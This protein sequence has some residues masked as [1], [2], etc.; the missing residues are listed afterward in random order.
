MHPTCLNELLAIFLDNPMTGTNSI[1]EFLTQLFLELKQNR[2]QYSVLRN[3][4][5]LPNSTGGSDIDMWVRNMDIIK[6]MSVFKQVS[7]ASRLSLVSYFG[8]KTAVKI[9]LQNENYGVQFDLFLGAIYYKETI[10]VPSES[11]IR[12]SISY[13][14]ITVLNDSFSDLLAYLKELVNNTKVKEKYTEP[15]LANKVVYS[16]DYLMQ[17][18][19]SFDKKFILALSHSIYTS[20]INEDS[21]HLAKLCRSSLSS[22]NQVR[23]ISIWASKIERL[24]RPKPGYVIAVEGTDGSGKSFIINSITPTLNEAFH[25]G[26]VYKHLRPHCIPDIAELFGKRKKETTTEATHVVSDPHAERS[27]GFAGSLVRWLYYMIDYTWGYMRKVWLPIHS[28]SK[29]F[30]FDRY[31]YEYYLDQRRSHVNLPMWIIRM[32]EFFIPKPDLIICLGGDPEKIYARKP[33]TSLEEVRRQTILLKEFCSK[34][35]NA[36][37][38]DTTMKPE[39]SVAAAMKAVMEVMS[40]RFDVNDL[41]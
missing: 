10:L 16:F 35:K 30:I 22:D 31:Y 19:I 14:G 34:R 37:W 24:C 15:I 40:K 17:S 21:S 4:K 29:V 33:E 1:S 5:N 36:V 20:A 38:V 6:C 13:N 12:N 23:K 26:I 41:Q 8:D 9:C 32:G 27:S 18:L 25:N 7:K 3:A 28:K 39:E 11:I 2:V